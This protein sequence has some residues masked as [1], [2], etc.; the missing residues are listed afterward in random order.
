MSMP[1]QQS[2]DAIFTLCSFDLRVAHRAVDLFN[3]G[4][5]QYLIF[6]GG[7]GKHTSKLFAKPEAEVFADVALG[8]G[9]PKEKIILERESTNTGENVRFTYTLLQAMGLRPRTLIL[10][11]SPYMERRTYA[12]FKK[13]WPDATVKFSVTSPQ[14]SFEEY[15]CE[16]APKNF[17]FAA[18]VETLLRMKLYPLKEFQIMQEIPDDV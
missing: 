12:T 18:M 2:A 17:F 1:I 7:Y 13:Q 4:R 6:S 9:V 16:A 14:L 3:C 8:R 5:G 15:P 10:V 11:Q